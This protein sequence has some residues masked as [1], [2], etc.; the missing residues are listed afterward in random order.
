M[1]TPALRTLPKKNQVQPSSMRWLKHIHDIYNQLDSTLLQRPDVIEAYNQ[2]YDHMDTYKHAFAMDYPPTN[3]RYSCGILP[4]RYSLESIHE[5]MTRHG[6][7]MYTEDELKQL[8]IEYNNNLPYYIRRYTHVYPDRKIALAGMLHR[9]MNRTDIKLLLAVDTLEGTPYDRNMDS[10]RREL[11][12]LYGVLFD[13]VKDV[14]EPL[15]LKECMDLCRKRHVD[16]LEKMI[17]KIHNQRTR[18]EEKY[19][20]K[21]KSTEEELDRIFEELDK[22]SVYQKKLEEKQ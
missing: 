14:I 19:K 4:T 17:Q 3:M 8:S 12:D 10:V 5:I 21:M 22:W 11:T 9:K 16:R 15:I 18:L 7:L 20:L 13:K 6:V 1:T 2:L